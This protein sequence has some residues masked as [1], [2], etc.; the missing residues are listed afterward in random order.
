MR[1]III[2]LSFIV[3][4]SC[5]TEVQGKY[6]LTYFNE[7]V[8]KE[9]GSPNTLPGTNNKYW[10]VCFPKVNHNMIIRKSDNMII[11]VEEGCN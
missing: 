1:K 8:A 5:K 2:G 10:Y 9:L 11:S 4:L 3:L 6:N 7:S